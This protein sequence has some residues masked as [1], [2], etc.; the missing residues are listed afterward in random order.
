LHLCALGDSYP[1]RAEAF[2]ELVAR[3]F[4]LPEVEEPWVAS[5]LGEG[6][7]EATH[8]LGS[9]ERIGE[10]AL[11]PRDLRPQGA[12]RGQLIK[13]QVRFADRRNDLRL[14]RLKI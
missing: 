7:V 14:P 12:P 6:L 5:A 8:R 3:P 9:H 2:G 13:L 11:E 4:Q 1:R 10:L